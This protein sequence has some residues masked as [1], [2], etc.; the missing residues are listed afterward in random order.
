MGGWKL[1]YP[2]WFNLVLR[3]VGLIGD[4][5][6]GVRGI[7]AGDLRERV[8][9]EEA[10]PWLTAVEML[11]VG[12]TARA[13]ESILIFGSCTFGLVEERGLFFSRFVCGEKK[14]NDG[15]RRKDYV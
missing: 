15:F 4:G 7:M 12:L 8:G 2:R 1:E 3:A 14:G 5:E 9:R 11:S 10:A 13:P 6:M